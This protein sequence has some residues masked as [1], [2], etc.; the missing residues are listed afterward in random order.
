MLY[1]KVQVKE[2]YAIM[3]FKIYRGHALSDIYF[4]R[5]WDVENWVLALIDLSKII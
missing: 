1:I 4:F 3:I 2:D 5:D